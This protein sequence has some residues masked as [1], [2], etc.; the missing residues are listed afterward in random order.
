[1]QRVLSAILALDIVD[2]S[3][4]MGHDD[5]A[6]LSELKTLFDSVVKIVDRH[7]GRVF[8]DA[9]DGLLVAFASPVQALRSALEIRE[10]V[11]APLEATEHLH[12]RQALALGDVIVDGDQ[13]YGE[14]VNIAARLQSLAEPGGIVACGAFHEQVRRHVAAH[15][16]S[17]GRR[18]LKNIEMPVEVLQLTTGPPA[19]ARRRRLGMALAAA[20]GL[21]VLAAIAS[22]RM[23][24]ET[25][26]ESQV[27]HLAT[28][29]PLR[30]RGPAIAVA[31]FESLG[32]DARFRV[33]ADGIVEDIT[34][35]LSKI[36]QLQVAARNTTRTVAR[37]SIGPRAIAS[38]LGTSHVLEG[39]IR[40]VGDKFRINA[41]LVDG[42]DGRTVWGER[43][44]VSPHDIF[45]VQ[46]KIVDGV[47]AAMALDLS[48]DEQRRIA[49]SD[50]TSLAAYENF[51]SGIQLLEEKTPEALAEALVHLRAA[52]AIDPDYAAANA[53]IGQVYWWSWVYGWEESIGETWETA[54]GRAEEYLQ[55]ALLEPNAVAYRLA[56]DMNL[57]ARR[58]DEALGFAQLAV[59]DDPN[60][61]AGHIIRAETLIYAGRPTEGRPWVELAMRLDPLFPAYVDFVLGMSYFGEGA[62]E[63]AVTQFELALERNPEDFGPA[64]PLAAALVHL[65]RQEAA[66]VAFETYLAGWPEANLD[67][68]VDYWPFQHLE[69]EER[70]TGPLRQLG[71]PQ[72]P[73]A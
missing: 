22:Y 27:A 20:V 2:Y 19:T 43:Y 42:G 61:V 11:H 50:T 54:P 55:R 9:G 5:E 48:S 33:L 52:L 8:G 66:K 16:H 13:L 18:R 35:D 49:R 1:M 21:A 60:D 72:S 40:E 68:L 28:L 34:T 51:R 12:I 59:D 30:E 25:G 15:F 38:S 37:E 41:R 65:D 64:A 53:A 63:E 3:L 67:E 44:D 70:L 56:A 36:H 62:F 6:T 32:D 17:L 47:V 14:A 7:D 45:G 39:T 31:P 57:Y 26:A 73:P 4:H 10:Q 69:D 24:A 71:M 29:A 46:K 58:F 23:L